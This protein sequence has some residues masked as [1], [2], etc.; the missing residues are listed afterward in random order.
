[1]MHQMIRDMGRKLFFKNRLISENEAGCGIRTRSIIFLMQGSKTIKCL[2]LDL[3]GL[4]ENKSRKTETTTLHFPK[5]SG[6]QI[7]LSNDVDMKTQAF[8]KI[9]RLKLL[10]LDNISIS[11]DWLFSTCATIIL[12]KFGRIKSLLRTPNLS[13]LPSLEKLKLKDCIKLVEV[14]QSIGE[15]KM[16]T[17]LTLKD[18][19]SL[20]KLPR[21]IGSLISLEE[22]ILSGSTLDNVPTELHDMKS[23]KVKLSLESCRLSDDAMPNDLCNLASLK[24]LSL[25]RNSFHCLP[26]S[27]KHLTKLDE[28]ILNC[29]TDLQVIPKL[30]I[31]SNSKEAFMTVSPFNLSII[32]SFFFPSKQCGIF[33]CEKL[34]EVQEMFKIEPIENFEAEE[35]TRLFSVDSIN[36]NRVQLYNFVIDRMRLVTPQ[37]LQECGITSTF[38]I[39]SEVPVGF[40]HSI[41][42]QKIP[43]SLPTPSNPKQRFS[44]SAYASSSP[45][46]VNHWTFYRLEGGDL[47][48]CTVAS[49]H[50]GIRKLGVTYESGE[51]LTYQHDFTNVIPGD[52]C[53][54]RNSKMDLTKDLLGLDYIEN[55]KVQVCN[56]LEES[57]VITSPRVLYDCGIITAFPP[58][59]FDHYGRYFGHHSGKAEVSISMTPFPN[60]SRKTS[61]LLNSI[62]VLSANNDKTSEFLPCLEVV[63]QTKGTKWTYSK[64]FMGIP[65]SN[66]LYW[67]ISW[68]FKGDEL[69]VGDHISFRVLS[70]L[71]V[72]ELSLHMI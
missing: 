1:M 16:P 45:S 72:L 30:P 39:G 71:C 55:V 37:V 32:P 8:V 56:Y 48:S 3:Q 2:A 35:I 25:S 60:S 19:K 21:T 6:D 57:T 9:Q 42:E 18:C 29:C 50:L 36:N 59:P 51:K 69:E 27:I 12:N 17:F 40:K 61:Y 26:E 20:R 53:A 44:G 24:Y 66:S 52:E 22:L 54:T 4:L 49:I 11:E 65:E 62:I 34:T 10:Q 58:M 15:L 33:G 13:G 31:F 14:D 5:R 70:D 23:L 47:M 63:N 68:N 67:V 41:D 64:H 43:F 7:L 28:L 46:S 38:V